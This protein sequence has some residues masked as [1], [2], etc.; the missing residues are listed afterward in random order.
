MHRSGYSFHTAIGHVDEV[1]SRLVEIGATQAPLTDRCSTFGFIKWTKAAKKLNLR[2]L[3]GVELAVVPE[4][5]A[6][7][8]IDHVRFMAIDSLAPLNELIGLATSNPGKE[9]SLLYH[10]ALE[11]KG[12]IKIFGERAR[13]EHMVTRPDVYVGL[14]PAISK[15]FYNAVNKAGHQWCAIDS[16]FYPR[17]DDQELYRVMLGRLRA[18]TRTYPGHILSKD[19]WRAALSYIASEQVMDEAL[20]RC[21]S[22]LGA[23][24]AELKTAEIFIPEKPFTLLE[25]CKKGA[26]R[27]GIDLNNEVYSKRMEREL[28]LIYDKKFEDYFYIIADLI[29]YAKQHMIVGPAR[30]SSC[31]S[32]VCYLLNITTIDP[33]PYNLIFERFIDV[34]RLDLPDIDIDFS[35]QRRHMVFT[36]AEEK[37][38]LEHIARLGTVTMFQPTSAMNQTGIALRIPKF[39]IKATL[40]GMIERS[41]GDSRANNSLEDTLNETVGG[42]ALIKEFPEVMLAARMEN[43]PN[44]ASKHAAGIVITK[45]R[46]TD[47]VA[48]DSRTKSTMCD[49]YDAEDYKLLKIDA[50]GLTQL[51]IIERTLE[52]IGE[53]TTSAGGFL[54]QIKLNDPAAFEVINQR[55]WAGIFQYSGSALQSLAKQFTSDNIEDI[56]SVTALA[57]PGPLASGGANEWVKRRN[58]QNPVVYPHPLFEPHLKTSLGITIYQ[59]QIMELGRVVGDLSW[60]DVTSLRKAMSKSL[61]KEF[62]DKYGEKW[63]PNAIK[64]GIPANVVNKAWDDMCTFG[65]WCFNRSHAVAYGLISYQCMYLKAHWPMEFAAATLD[66]ESEPPKQ[67]AFLRELKTEGID[68]IPVDIDHSTDRWAPVRKGNRAYLVGPLGAIHGIGP[69]AIDKILSCRKNGKPLPDGITKK[70]QNARTELDSLYPVTDQVHKLKPGWEPKVPLSQIIDVQCG[71]GFV[72]IAAVVNRIAPRDDNDLANVKKRGGYKVREPSMALNMTAADDSDSV[73]ARI[74]RFHFGQMAPE[75]IERGK[76]G[77]ALYAIAGVVPENFRMIKVQYILYLGDMDKSILGRPVMTNPGQINSDHETVGVVAMNKP[78]GQ[79]YDDKDRKPK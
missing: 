51:S 37:Y 53:D 75:I 36:Y 67:L 2:P 35:D 25:M 71:S 79:V 7:P 60:E 3:Y 26:E 31:G 21:E 42:K 6:K 23:C 65:S 69:K 52:L 47:V 15:G 68:Y 49:K 58:G 34:N 17:E 78:E 28:K 24:K 11:A 18:E 9:P 59:E 20:Q 54:D 61:G 16:N 62:F 77:K 8:I 32:L 46:V 33:I 64:K 45:E 27:L 44:N 72:M 41:S 38:G 12:V 22:I 4:F 63:K 73:L 48:I 74:D 43:H 66:A 10:E 13:L 30:G 76:A 50:L 70:L 56:I 57:R 39:R 19:E 1:L 5:S 55:R 40:E 14:S 29:D